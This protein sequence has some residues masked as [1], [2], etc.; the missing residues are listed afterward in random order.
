MYTSV[1]SKVACTSTK[2]LGQFNMRLLTTVSTYCTSSSL[3]PLNLQLNERDNLNNRCNLVLNTT[4]FLSL[5][6][7][8]VTLCHSRL[9]EFGNCKYLI[10]R[11]WNVFASNTSHQNTYG[12]SLDRPVLPDRPAKRNKKLRFGVRIAVVTVQSVV[13][14][15]NKA[16]GSIFLCIEKNVW[17]QA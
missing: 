9:V 13:W 16:K 1:L 12:L 11:F 5:I 4:L 7:W 17:T 2:E 8:F 3:W 15:A 6:Y 10:V 14:Q